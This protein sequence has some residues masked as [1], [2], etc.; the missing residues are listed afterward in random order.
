MRLLPLSWWSWL[1]RL[2][3]MAGSVVLIFEGKSAEASFSAE[4][5]AQGYRQGRVLVKTK[6]FSTVA[7][8]QAEL[9]VLQAE[10]RAGVRSRR[11][12]RT[13]TRQHLLE[14]DRSESIPEVVARLQA[15]GLYEFVEP[16][17]IRY[18]QVIP[19]DPRFGEQWALN[20]TGQ[21][22]GSPDADIDAPEGWDVAA[23]AST[24]I[25]AVVDTGVRT[26][27]EDL[28]GNLWVNSREIP[29]NGRDDDNN[30]YIDDVNGINAIVA[31]GSSGSGSPADD[32]GHG[33]HVAGI[34]GAVGNN[35]RG[36]AGVAWR[37]KIM[38]LKFL[39]SEGRGSVA[40]AAECIDY[41]LANGAR[42]INAS[43]GALSTGQGPSQTE[44]AAI[45]RAR[46]AGIIFVAA[47]G[48]DG[49]NLD[50]ARTFPATYALDNIVTVGNS[51]RLEDIATSSNTGSGAV[52]LFAPGSEI[53]A[54]S[55][56]SDSSYITLTGTSMAAP[57]VTGAVALLR[58][59]Y[60]T[61]SHRQIIN[62][63][64]RSVDPIP[65]YRGRVQTGGRLNLYKALL[66][67]DTRPFNDDFN[68]RAQ[69]QGELVQVR[70]A[71]SGATAEVGEPAHAGFSPGATLW[72]T[73]TAPVSGEVSVDTQG[74][75]FDTVLA[76]YTGD[77]LVGI[78]LV[79]ANDNGTIGQA[80]R[81]TFLAQ[82]GTAY[83]LA[84]G[85]KGDAN[86]LI[87]LNLG[88]VPANDDFASAT[89]LSPEPAPITATNAKASSQLGEPAHAG[90][91]ARRSLWYR[92]VAGNSTRVYAAVM[93]AQLNPV[94][95]VYTGTS[96]SNL[97]PIASDV[98][99]ATDAEINHALA[100]FDAIAGTEYVI[101]VDSTLVGSTEV[102]GEFVFTL[103][104]AAWV[105]S[106][107]DSI[108][109]SPVVGSDGTVY[110]GA[111]DSRFYAFNGL[112]GS[113]KWSYSITPATLIDTGTAAVGPDGTVYFGAFN[114][115]LYALKD[116]GSQASVRWIT[117]LGAPITNAPAIG[118]DGTLYIRI[119]RGVTAV[120]AESQLVAV[121]AV[122]GTVKWRY[123]FG[124]EA[125]YAAP[126]IGTNGTVYVA[127]G[128]GALHAV[129]PA[130]QR[131]WRAGV[132]GQIY[133][134][135]AIDRDGNLYVASLNGTA[136]SF[137][138]AGVQRWRTVIGGFVSSSLAVAFGKVYLASYDKN[139]YAL[140]ASTGAKT[141]SYALGDEVR[142]SSPAVAQ[143]GSVF[144][145][146]YDR[147][148][149]HVNADGT[150]RRTYV[151]AGW[152][153]SSP[154]LARGK[155]YIGNND[156]RLYAFEVGL[157]AAVGT[158]APWPQHRH[159][160]RRTGR[161]VEGLDDPPA[162]GTDF[163]Q[164]RL[165]NLS[166]RT[167]SGQGEGTLIAG[168]ILAGEAAP[169]KRLV[170]ARGIGPQLTAF[171]VPG[172]L[173]DP[174][175]TLKTLGG[176]TLARNDNWGGAP[177]LVEVASRVG[178]F[179]LPDT[180]SRDAALVTELTA[181]AYTA[182][183][184]SADGGSGIALAEVYDA[185]SPS[186]LRLANVSVRARSGSGADV[187]IAGFVISDGPR[188][189]LIRG[190]G[191]GLASYGVNGVVP[192]P[193]IEV[194]QGRTLIYENNDWQGAP[195]VTDA[196]Q[197]VGAFALTLGSR[198]SALVARLEPGAYTVQLRDRAGSPGVGLIEVYEL[199]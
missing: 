153:R 39:S 102:T 9:S 41:A 93:S 19:N 10:A 36:T 7:G 58:A 155:L 96:L 13:L 156:G 169:A 83:Q 91:A 33:T 42:V 129:S 14:V 57:Q 70:A 110:V 111:N 59:R 125:S 97:T 152:F 145:G 186:G 43:Y 128:D 150:R 34:I 101:A 157:R 71:S 109:S 196:S 16:D 63:L 188:T 31:R 5:V 106:A 47:A 24:V 52:D 1:L 105:A 80:S 189:V 90:R 195:D 124:Q 126:S 144:I 197:R 198:D 159:N 164:G 190:V 146:G 194:Y 161:M 163:G 37:V 134:S 86:G 78:S 48:N 181:G 108:T 50:I 56:S 6:E 132:D 137:T 114:G 147:R 136:Y 65:K 75:A 141:W 35:G 69:L 53:L 46:E 8:A 32:N 30:G 88:A 29:G 149:H 20:N 115:S 135:P 28:V 183:V 103:S 165:I 104:E 139:L 40:D 21:S 87:L 11:S 171:E 187:V 148:V 177:S 193:R 72:W 142:A 180:S 95:A 174:V 119:E 160:V 84:V 120:N 15:T 44:I 74:S 54:L 89:V 133:S 191:P 62:R 60:P 176:V 26:S 92:W 178:A 27:H 85:G 179:V 17:A 121:E 4:E 51:T 168:F 99:T 82:A 167:Q 38:P 151:G 154:L 182:E 123:P 117:A 98:S 49:L 138:A 140:D 67:D 116:E 158:A 64:L 127:G 122:S 23:D 175:L 118:D 192:D 166:V 94:V 79:A 22:S 143:D 3:V 73:W 173:A 68:A 131:L 81:L 45:Q 199:R 113:V 76:V 162:L 107:R 25:V 66:Q 2:M 184:T 172:A 77:S 130:G 170:L 100:G 112:D 55:S 12:F 185:S 18:T 61:D